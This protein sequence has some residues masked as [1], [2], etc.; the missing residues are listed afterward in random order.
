MNGHVTEWLPSYYDGELHGPRKYQVEEHLKRCPTCRT[1]LESLQRISILLQEAPLPER[2]LAPGHF[3]SQVML[4]L[5]PAVYRPGWQQALKTGWQL[6][7]AGAI[8]VWVFWQ[9]IWLVGSFAWILSLPLN[10]SGAGVMSGW[11]GLGGANTAWRGVETFLEL[12]LLNL[13][14]T[15]L[16][17]LFLCGWLATWWF[18]TRGVSPNRNGLLHNP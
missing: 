14:I 18:A 10:L 17:A 7:P 1:E 11:F 2:T 16:V 12:G 3:Q 5:P 8:L 15:A 13:V 4:R 6:A 9:G